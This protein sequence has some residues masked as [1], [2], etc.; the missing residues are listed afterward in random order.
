LVASGW[1]VLSGKLAMLQT[2]MFDGLLT[3]SHCFMMARALPK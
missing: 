1:L 3:L 2:P